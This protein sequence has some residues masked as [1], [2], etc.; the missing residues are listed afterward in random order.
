M[1]VKILSRGSACLRSSTDRYP[2]ESGLLVSPSARLR[3][4]LPSLGWRVWDLIQKL[5]LVVAFV[6]AAAAVTS[7]AQNG[8]ERAAVG[9]AVDD[10]MLPAN[11]HTFGEQL[12][13]K[14]QLAGAAVKIVGEDKFFQEADAPASR[15]G[16]LSDEVLKYKV[17]IY[18]YTPVFRQK[19]LD[20][21]ALPTSGG[22]AVVGQNVEVSALLATVWWTQKRFWVFEE[23]VYVTRSALV[24]KAEVAGSGYPRASRTKEM[25][26]II[27][28]KKSKDQKYREQPWAVLESFR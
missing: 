5:F 9:K 19:L 4:G 22:V 26:G 17:V 23:D 6:A 15:K 21:M 13:L 12:S 7:V 24:R 8:W 25:E 20:G 11:S 2:S 28:W 27:G 14:R 16:P 10:I 3:G 1:P 18:H